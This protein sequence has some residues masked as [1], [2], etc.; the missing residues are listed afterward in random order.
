MDRLESLLAG[1]SLSLKTFLVDGF[2]SGFRISY[3]GEYSHF[4][5][6]NLQSAL[7]SLDVAFAKLKKEI[8]LVRLWALS[9]LLLFPFFALRPLA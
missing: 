5:S 4:E 8:K 9:M 3:I 2:R 1:Y 6:P 7:H